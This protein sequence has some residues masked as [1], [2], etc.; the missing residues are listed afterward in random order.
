MKLLLAEP[1]WLDA[2]VAI[3]INKAAVAETGEGFHLRDRPALEAALANPQHAFHYDGTAD[4][5]DLAVRYIHSVAMAHAFEQGNKRTALACGVVFLQR[6]ACTIALPD[7]P[8]L[9][10]QMMVGL[11]EHRIKPAD[12]AKLMRPYVAMA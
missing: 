3:A 1:K 9:I 10:E 8:E 5:I 11:I 7:D 12:F 2:T 6:H 4:L